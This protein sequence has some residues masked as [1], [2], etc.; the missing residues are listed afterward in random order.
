MLSSVQRDDNAEKLRRPHYLQSTA[1]VCLHV[2]YVKLQC[3]CPLLILI[4]III[5]QAGGWAGR[6]DAPDEHT[7]THRIHECFQQGLQCAKPATSWKHSLALENC[8]NNHMLCCALVCH[9][10]PQQKLMRSL[11]LSDRISTVHCVSCFC[12]DCAAAPAR[13][14]ASTASRNLNSTK[15]IARQL[16]PTMCREP[17]ALPGLFC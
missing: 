9:V 14:Q 8:V 11:T 12:I 15:Q 17:A 3:P 10:W 6:M 13:H 1:S 4:T 2:L 16:C 7:E 5:A